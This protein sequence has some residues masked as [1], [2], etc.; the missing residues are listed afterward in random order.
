MNDTNVFILVPVCW[1]KN[2]L[3]SLDWANH[4]KLK[5]TTILPKKHALPVKSLPVKLN[6]SGSGKGEHIPEPL[7]II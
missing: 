5:P 7:Y 2:W 1:T 4:S 6:V 3:G